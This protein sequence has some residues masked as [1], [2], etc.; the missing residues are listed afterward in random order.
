MMIESRMTWKKIIIYKRIF[1]VNMP[2]DVALAVGKYPS[3]LAWKSDKTPDYRLRY[4]LF[5]QGIMVLPYEKSISL[6]IPAIRQKLA[7]W[8]I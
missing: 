5:G 2:C 1:I 6:L 4:W 8:V 3:W 7:I